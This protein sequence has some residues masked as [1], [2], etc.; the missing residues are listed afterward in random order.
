MHKAFAL[1]TALAS[2]SLVAPAFAD[3]PPKAAPDGTYQV[4][5]R[6]ALAREPTIADLSHAERAADAPAPG[7]TGGS[8]APVV[9]GGLER[10]GDGRSRAPSASTQPAREIA[11]ARA[12]APAERPMAGRRVH[13]R[14]DARR[15]L[16][17]LE[18]EL[19]R[20]GA[21]GV[22]S[23]PIQL[24]LKL[25]VTAAGEVERA[26][27]ADAARASAPVVA[28][29]STVASSA[30]FRSPG[31]LGASLVVPVSLPATSA[32]PVA[33]ASPARPTAGEAPRS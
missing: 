2:L 10:I 14:M 8:P 31:G 7:T 15:V 23:T 30:R 32:V 13:E 5:T 27:V 9:A 21:Q 20:C 18:P 26:S 3:P 4:A 1:S 28:C 11:L 19:L 24:V 12:D 6:A 29:L 17:A 33:P 22:S 16:A 25:S